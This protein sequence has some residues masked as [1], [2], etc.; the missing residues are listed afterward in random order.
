MPPVPLKPHI[1]EVFAQIGKSVLGLHFQY[2]IRRPLGDLVIVVLY[3]DLP[4]AVSPHDHTYVWID[5]TIRLT[6]IAEPYRR[7]ENHVHTRSE[8]TI[9]VDYG[10]H[11]RVISR[12]VRIGYP[13]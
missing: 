5:H 1:S 7:E 8:H 6:A 4:G 9:V 13:T 12:N 3:T 2:E 10:K 11:V